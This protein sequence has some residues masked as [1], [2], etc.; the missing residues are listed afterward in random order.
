MGALFAYFKSDWLR[1]RGRQECIHGYLIKK[2][3]RLK[4]FAD[5]YLREMFEVQ[6]GDF[7]KKVQKV[8]LDFLESVILI[9]TN[10]KFV[11]LKGNFMIKANYLRLK[12]FLLASLITHEISFGS[13]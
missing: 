11:K 8:L 3:S 5:Q 2:N 7:L 13:F 4:T 9:V 12:A 10:N 6:K 1:N